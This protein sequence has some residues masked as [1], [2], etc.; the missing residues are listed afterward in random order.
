[1]ITP[2]NTVI[3]GETYEFMPMGATE[4]RNWLMVLQQTIGPS[5]AEAFAGVK[6]AQIPEEA[7]ELDQN[8]PKLLVAMLGPI[9]GSISGLISGLTRSLNASMYEKLVEAFL[10]RTT[11][12]TPTG[13]KISLKKA[14]R[15]TEF[16]NKLAL[17]GR[18]LFWCLHEQ[19]ADFFGYWETARVFLNKA[20]EA[21][22][23]LLKSQQAS[24][25]GS[26][27]SQHLKDSLQA[28]P[29]FNVNGPL[30]T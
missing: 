7:L 5:V 1:M 17:E 6:G 27:E 25:G 24:N 4:A 9:A 30:P 18:I 23:S 26:S 22:G 11:I 16:Y 29:K 21:A 28:S 19:Y 10:S 20:K 14:Y 8:D 13:G 15:E 12:E 3:D 2:V